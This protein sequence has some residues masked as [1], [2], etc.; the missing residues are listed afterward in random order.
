MRTRL[1]NCI[2]WGIGA[3]LISV[4]SVTA[5]SGKEPLGV[6][7]IRPTPSLQKA[8]TQAGKAA[9]LQRVIE[10]FDGQLIDRINA[11]RKFEV[12]GRS[13]LKEVF[14]EQELA[15]SGNV[16]VLDKKA[17]QAGKLAGAKYLLVTTLD[18]FE[19]ST[20]RMEFPTLKQ[21]GIKRK[22]RISTVAKIYDSSTGKLLESANIQRMIKDDRAD[23]TSLQKN[24]ELTDELLVS[25]VRVVAEESAKRVA[26][27]VFPVK[28]L[29]RRDAQI[30]VN[31]G[32]GGGLEV[33]QVWNVYAVGDM[34]I[35]PDTKEPLGREEVL[36]GKARIIEVNPKMSKGEI[37]EDR[38]IAPG[39]VLRLPQGIPAGL[40]PS[41]PPSG[42]VTK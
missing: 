32:E 35:D 37:I 22:I 41:M 18:D 15:G 30:T 11:T 7:A 1:L 40:P 4:I 13:D 5:Q 36:V 26:D 6:A 27:V 16:D 29:V 42:S 17:A 33:G 23:S 31:R 3:L 38:G 2:G 39:S 34:L 10:S 28:V 19:D 20:E 25:V 12:V 8:M 21:V 24:A 14:K 9:S